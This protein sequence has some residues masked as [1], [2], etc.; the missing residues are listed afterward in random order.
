M[1]GTTMNLPESDALRER[2]IELKPPEKNGARLAAEQ[3][4]HTMAP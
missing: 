3:H 4:T 2:Y 1:L